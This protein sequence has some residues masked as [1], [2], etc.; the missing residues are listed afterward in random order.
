MSELYDDASKP[1][2]P[3]LNKIY[4]TIIKDAKELKHELHEDVNVKEI[5]VDDFVNMMCYPDS[6]SNSVFEPFM[7]SCA[8]YQ[9]DELKESSLPYTQIKHLYMTDEY[10]RAIYRFDDQKSTPLVV[11]VFHNGVKKLVSI[12]QHVLP[13]KTFLKLEELR[14]VKNEMLSG[15][16]HDIRSE[17]PV[18]QGYVKAYSYEYK[19]SYEFHDTTIPLLMMAM[20]ILNSKYCLA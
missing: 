19:C 7:D 18:N 15:A 13:L 14:F 2:T 1:P 3:E 17:P 9:R 5:K 8:T 16:S 20:T 12:N 10:N 6:E 4:D 11:V